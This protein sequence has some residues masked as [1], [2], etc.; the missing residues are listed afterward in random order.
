[1]ELD[2][3][4][5]SLV[6]KLYCFLALL[7]GPASPDMLWKSWVSGQLTGKYLGASFLFHGNRNL[8]FPWRWIVLLQYKSFWNLTRI[9][10]Q[11]FSL[12]SWGSEGRGLLALIRKVIILREEG[13]LLSWERRVNVCLV[14]SIP[15]LKSCGSLINPCLSSVLLNVFDLRLGSKRSDSAQKGV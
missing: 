15:G 9:L 10:L 6:M 11:P 3:Y 5:G 4:P 12:W 13:K 2:S 7:F 8:I 1:M 14:A